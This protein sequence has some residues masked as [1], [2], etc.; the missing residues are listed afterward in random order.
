MNNFRIIKSKSFFKF[1]F[2]GLINLFFTNLILQISL[3]YLPIWLCTLLSQIINFL[4]G[5]YLYGI[6]VF[7]NNIKSLKKF[8]KYLII[9]LFSW[10]FNT[11]FIY[12]FSKLIGYSEN[13][14]AIIVIPFI[15]IYSFLAQKYFVFKNNTL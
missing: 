13:L 6:F 4:I 11:C 12:F 3:V 5:F 1:L 7:K 9:A 14:A 2:L 8:F 15:V 10:I